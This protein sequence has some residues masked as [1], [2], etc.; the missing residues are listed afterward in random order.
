[1]VFQD[2][3]ASFVAIPVS[4]NGLGFPVVGWRGRLGWVGKIPIHELAEPGTA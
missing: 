2:N 1:M 4:F 3:N